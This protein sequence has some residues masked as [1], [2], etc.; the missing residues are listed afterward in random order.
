MEETKR[1]PFCAETIQAAAIVCRHCGRDLVSP[2][3]APPPARSPLKRW[4]WLGVIALVALCGFFN[5]L[6]GDDRPRSRSGSGSGSTARAVVYTLTGTAPRASLTERTATGNEQRDARLPYRRAFTVE[7][8]DFL[9]I[10]AQIKGNQTLSN[11]RGRLTATCKITVDGAVV[12]EAEAVG[13]SH[14]ATCSARAP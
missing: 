14:I 5:A 9:Y 3:A 8:G 4:F 10:S 1:C 6:D 7:Q 11:P 13:L 2:V 12:S